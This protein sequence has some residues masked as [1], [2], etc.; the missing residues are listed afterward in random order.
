[1]STDEADLIRRAQRDV[2]AFGP[3]YDRYVGRIYAFA[4]RR[5]GEAALA[6]DVTSATFEKA[7]KNLPRFRWQGVGFGA[8]LYRIARNEIAQAYR[9]AR[10]AGP[11]L[12]WHVL[13]E[14]IAGNGHR[15]GAH[16]ALHAAFAALPDSDRELLT[17]RFFEDLSSRELAEVLGCS[18]NNVYVRVHRA[19]Q[20]LR[21]ELER[22]Q[23]M[24]AEHA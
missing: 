8:W 17:L 3:L 22:T 4:Y 9:R 23:A 10:A 2:R 18:V 1:M 12:E 15:D 11:L 21:A 6:Q 19:L 16:D 24:E 13:D 5:T 20:R 7:L 14:T